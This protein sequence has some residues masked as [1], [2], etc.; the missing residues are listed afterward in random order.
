MIPICNSCVDSIIEGANGDW[1]QVD[2]LCQYADIPFIPRE[3]EEIYNTNKYNAFYRYAEIFQKSDYD[4]IAWDDY[5]KAY[6]ELR[7]QKRLEEELP[8]LAE[9]KR[10]QLVSKWGAN[11]DDEALGYL[12]ELFNGLLSTQNINGKLQADQAMKICKMSYEIDRRIAEGSDF[13]KL[14][15][16]YDKL[17]KTAEF[18]PKNTKNLND[19]DTFGEATKWMEKHGW[20]NTFYDNVSRDVVDETLKNFQN[21]NQRLYINES[22]MGEQITQRLEALKHT[23]EMENY[24]GTNKNYTEESDDSPTEIVAPADA[25]DDSEFAADILGGDDDE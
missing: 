18:T 16:S 24:Y 21:F 8:E 22:G 15:T 1:S 4:T 11:Y 10:K 25:F 19:F 17:V 23:A 5:Y 12:E 2:K 3:W 13:D 20:R 6:K 9:E 14:L 7:N